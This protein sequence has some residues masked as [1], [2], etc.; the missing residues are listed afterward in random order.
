MLEEVSQDMR[1][2]WPGK[3]ASL[4][5]PRLRERPSSESPFFTPGD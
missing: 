3:R 2:E 5:R 4:G 1:L